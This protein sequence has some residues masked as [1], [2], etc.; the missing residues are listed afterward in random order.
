MSMQAKP[1]GFWCARKVAFSRALGAALLVCAFAGTMCAQESVPPAQPEPQ[2]PSGPQIDLT[3]RPPEAAAVNTLPERQ[4]ALVVPKDTPVEVALEKDVRVRKVGQ[5]IHGRVVEPVYAF[6]KLV[7][8]AGTEINGRIIALKGVSTG[9]RTEAALD[10]DFTPERKVQ[11]EFEELAL[12]DGKRIPIQTNVTP[13]S[14]EVVQLVSGANREGDKKGVHDLA[15][16]KTKE[17]KQQARQEWDRA[18]KQ[19]KDPGK[20]HRIGRYAVDQL[21]AHPQYLDAGTVYLAELQAPLD[22]GSEPL[23]A[24]LAATLA[25]PVLPEGSVVQARLATPLNS[26]TTHQGDE[27]RAVVSKPLFDGGHLIVPEGSVLRG[28]VVQ[29]RAARR[30]SHNGELRP[31]FHELTLPDGV[32]QQVEATMAAVQAGKKQDL[33]LDS[34]G[35]A[36]A[37]APRTR[38]LQSAIAVGLA[39]A[40]QGDDPGNRAEGGAGGFRVIGIALGLAVRSQ[41]LGLTMGAIG[42]GRSV[43]SHFLA[44]G[45]DVVLP[46]DT[47]MQIAIG[48]Q[49]DVPSVPPATPNPPKQ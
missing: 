24:Q 35:G 34:E 30:M 23:S 22:F 5:P 16:E 6:D 31:V 38:Y 42:A 17:A 47:A 21:P 1:G 8:P 43:Y 33:K 48:T 3:H 18:M 4:V 46:K 36:A 9:R 20:F 44:R 19:L 12:S 14:G 27:V 45:R 41:P 2:S 26:A 40:S 29:V 7:I 15:A 25:N 10:A 13:D 11:V 28:L 37:Q 32:R 39:V 49:A